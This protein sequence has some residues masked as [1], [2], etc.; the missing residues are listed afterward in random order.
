MS[1]TITD[2]TMNWRIP[3]ATKIGAHPK[4]GD[5]RLG[6]TTTSSNITDGVTKRRS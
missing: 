2:A 6:T 5:G 3:K 4:T 1:T